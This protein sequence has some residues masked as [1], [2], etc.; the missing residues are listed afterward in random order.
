[1]NNCRVLSTTDKSH[2]TQVSPLDTKR[3]EMK[4]ANEAIEPQMR[5]MELQAA[6]RRESA[7]SRPLGGIK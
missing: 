5:E 7:R 2:V 6:A 1:M 3:K 4:E